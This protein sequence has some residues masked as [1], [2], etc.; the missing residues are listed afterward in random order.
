MFDLIQ[1]IVGTLPLTDQNL[2]DSVSIEGD[3]QEKHP[4]PGPSEAEGP[5][6]TD[7]ATKDTSD[8]LPDLKGNSEIRVQNLVKASE[9]TLT[10]PPPEESGHIVTTPPSLHKKDS[11]ADYPP[12][13]Q[14]EAPL[15]TEDGS[16]VP[17]ADK[18]QCVPPKDH[19][20]DSGWA[21]Q[22]IHQIKTKEDI[23]G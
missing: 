8:S 7:T 10:T 12:K 1:H 21:I 15:D 20:L 22:Q 23:D 19:S 11:P 3:P 5:T 14:P 18:T 4:P 9:E 13:D 16:V 2:P 6:S 17:P